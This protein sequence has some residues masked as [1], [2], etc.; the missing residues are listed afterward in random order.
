MKLE[1]ISGIAEVTVGDI[2]WHPSDFETTSYL[3]T[4]V[5]I[6]EDRF[7]LSYM[8]DD[9]RYP[10]AWVDLGSFYGPQKMHRKV[11]EFLK[12]DPKQAGDTDDDI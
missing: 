12:Y 2:V 10:T 8:R 5:S 1:P 9:G 7:R 3:I 6:P 11:P 4:E